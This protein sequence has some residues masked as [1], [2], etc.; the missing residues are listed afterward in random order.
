MNQLDQ[1]LFIH[2]AIYSNPDICEEIADEPIEGLRS[3]VQGWVLPL[4]NSKQD[5]C[6]LTARELEELQV[7]AQ[8]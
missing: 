4:Q 8:T 7:Y 1:Y 5:E 2:D 6:V 3:Y